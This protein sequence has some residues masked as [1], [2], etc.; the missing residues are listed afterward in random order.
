MKLKLEG[1]RARFLGNLGRTS[2]W[3][4]LRILFMAFLFSPSLIYSLLVSWKKMKIWRNPEVCRQFIRR[5]PLAFEGLDVSTLRVEPVTGGVSNSNEI[6]KCKTVS[7]SEVSYFVKIFVRAGSFWA[8]H[9]SI[10]SPFPR[11]YGDKTHERFTVDMIS[12]VQLAE[13]GIAVPKLIAYDPVQKVMI[14]EYLEGI[15]I[16]EVLKTIHEKGNIDERDMLIIG[17]CGAGLAKVHHAG[18][19]LI[20]TQ[21]ANCIWV[22]HEQKIYFTDLEF[23]S[24]SDKRVWDVGF[25][26]CFLALRLKGE[27]KK[28]I[29]RIF[30]FSYQKERNLDFSGLAQIG[31]ELKDYL[32]IFE[33]ILDMRQFTPEELFEQL[34]L[35]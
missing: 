23:C 19:S 21:P 5:H 28:E 6:W 27:I 35:R 8:R 18:F 24:R 26:L 11:V 7:G 12:R 33:T 32:A 22:D 25:F 1:F 14:T 17:Q 2:P 20:D 10:V 3:L 34:W 30:I 31:R 15:N 13:K 9:L 29:S 4:V 16:D